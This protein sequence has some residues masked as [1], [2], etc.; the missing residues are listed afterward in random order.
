MLVVD[1]F[2]SD[3]IPMH[4]M[5]REAFELYDRVVRKTGWCSS[6]SPTGSSTWNR[7]WRG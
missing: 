3:A 7:S 5:T 6:T 2:S 1:A 4:L